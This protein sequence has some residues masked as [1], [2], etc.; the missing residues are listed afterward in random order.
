MLCR[1]MCVQEFRGTLA[2][3]DSKET[4]PSVVPSLI[5]ELRENIGPESGHFVKETE[6]L[7]CERDAGF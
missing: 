7:A 5:H 1:I 4:K 6:T 2:G 3:G